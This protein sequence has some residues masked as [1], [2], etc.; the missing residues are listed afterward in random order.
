MSLDLTKIDIVM[1]NYNIPVQIESR[2]HELY[3]NCVYCGKTFTKD[4]TIEHI[5]NDVGNISLK[6]IVLCCRSCNSSKGNK[7]LKDW[8]NSEYCSINNISYNTV[9]DVIKNCL[10]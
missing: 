4:A 10:Q 8:L 5:D 6:N 1:N 2:L 9:A 7:N 3:K